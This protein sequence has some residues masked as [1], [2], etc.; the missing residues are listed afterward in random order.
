MNIDYACRCLD[1]RGG[2]QQRLHSCHG[3]H[4]LLKERDLR[5]EHVH[6]PCE[7]AEIEYELQELP[8]GQSSRSCQL[9]AIPE[10]SDG[11]QANK[12]LQQ[13]IEESRQP[14]AAQIVLHILR[15]DTPEFLDFGALLGKCP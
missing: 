1:L 9:S 13:E 5:S 14:G 6:G 11:A 3:N 4:S 8:N 15:V 12:E 10:D 2:R 7:I